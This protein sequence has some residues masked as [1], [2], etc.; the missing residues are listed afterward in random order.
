MGRNKRQISLPEPA[1]VDSLFWTYDGQEELKQRITAAL[2]A[3]DKNTIISLV[4]DTALR[5]P[6]VCR[7]IFI[8][9]ELEQPLSELVG[10]VRSAIQ[11][12]T[13]IP[14]KLRNHNFHIYYDAYEQ[15]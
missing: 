10:D 13:F 7:H 9:S 1:S 12:A 5:W 11:N 8:Q 2:S 4:C 6:D 3:C 14:E 15:G